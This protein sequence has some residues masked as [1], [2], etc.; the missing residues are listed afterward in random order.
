MTTI[1]RYACGLDHR[2]MAELLN[3]II[4]AGGTTALTSTVSKSEIASWVAKDPDKSAW[5]VAEDTAGKLLGFQWIWPSKMHGPDAC[6]I[7]TFVALGQTGLGTG[8]ALFEKTKQ[9]ASGLAYRW[10]N[11]TIRADN[12]G[13]L[14]YYQSRGFETYT[15]Q[16][17]VPLSDG[18]IVDRI[19]KRFEL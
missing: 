3:K 10:I 15:T 12:A 18:Q 14:A 4:N 1:T 2:A 11:A 17:D 5:F 19:S 7:A 13:G 6:D 16:K 9:A 8:S